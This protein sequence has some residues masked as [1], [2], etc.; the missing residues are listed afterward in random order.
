MNARKALP[1]VVYALL[2]ALPGGCGGDD[3]DDAN[4]GGSAGAAGKSSGTGGKTAGTGGKTAGTGGKAAGGTTSRGGASNGGNTSSAGEAGALDAGSAGMSGGM[5]N[6]GAD[7]SGGTPGNGGAPGSGGTLGSGGNTSS[8]GGSGGLSTGGTS[9]SSGG[10]STTSGGSTSGGAG[11]AGGS[12]GGG[13]G[14]AGGSGGEGEPRFC[15]EQCNID[16]DCFKT[17]VSNGRICNPTTKRCEFHVCDVD[18]DCVP[19]GSAWATA[20]TNDA[21]CASTQTCVD[22]KGA[23]RCATVPNGSTCTGEQVVV[24]WPHFG[25]GGDVSVCADQ[26]MKCRVNSCVTPCQGPQ[27][28]ANPNTTCNSVTGLCDLCKTDAACGGTTKPPHCNVATGRCECWLNS[29]CTSVVNTNICVDGRCACSG[30]SACTRKTGQ[31]S[32]LICE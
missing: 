12:G 11:G 20:C 28:C 2:V 9:S 32:V 13:E 4:T 10:T 21:G 16:S 26:S 19:Q 30:T 22:V 27:D 24:Q 23:G 5:G 8:A 29:D 1:F 31:N 6:A 7:T 14:G 18:N 3:D 17:S 15:A 25:G